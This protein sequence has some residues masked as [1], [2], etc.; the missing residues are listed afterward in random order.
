M[1]ETRA[2]GAAFLA[3]LLFTILAAGAILALAGGPR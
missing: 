3:A 1:R 2:S